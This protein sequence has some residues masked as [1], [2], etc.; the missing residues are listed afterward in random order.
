MRLRMI[1]EDKISDPT[2]EM[3]AFFEKRTKEH[4]DRVGKLLIDLGSS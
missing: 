2:P 3:V 1:S 4:I